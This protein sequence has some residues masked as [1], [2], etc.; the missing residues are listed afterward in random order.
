MFLRPNLHSF[1]R[2]RYL[3]FVEDEFVPHAVFP[4][5]AVPHFGVF[6]VHGEVQQPLLERRFGPALNLVTG[7]VLSEKL[8]ALMFKAE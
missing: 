4:D 8:E 7:L 6:P 3:D 5:D 2:K 1:G